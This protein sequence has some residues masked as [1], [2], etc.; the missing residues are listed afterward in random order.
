[1][2]IRYIQKITDTFTQKPS[3]LRPLS[4]ALRYATAPKSHLLGESIKAA[5]L[6]QK[7]SLAVE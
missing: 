4:L 6:V 7:G 5:A 1:M 2:P 3:T